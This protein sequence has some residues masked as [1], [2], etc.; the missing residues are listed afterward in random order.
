MRHSVSHAKKPVISIMMKEPSAASLCSAIASADT[1][2]CPLSAS[3]AA[4]PL[5]YT[6]IVASAIRNITSRLTFF[7]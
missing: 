2:A 5:T 4:C 6:G 3:A 7:R 1:P